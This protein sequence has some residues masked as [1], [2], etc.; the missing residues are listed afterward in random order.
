MRDSWNRAGDWA[1]S[2]AETRRWRLW[3]AVALVEGLAATI[4]PAPWRWFVTVPAAAFGLLFVDAHARRQRDD[5]RTRTERVRTQQ[6]K[7]PLPG[8]AIRQYQWSRCSVKA[9]C[10]LGVA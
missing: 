8:V 1:H 2:L 7:V 4:V 9:G 10:P 3:V 5:D 6:E